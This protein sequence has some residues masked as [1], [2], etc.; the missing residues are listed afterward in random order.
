MLDT[1]EGFALFVLYVMT[2]PIR[3]ALFLAVLVFMVIVFAFAVVV[4][5]VGTLLDY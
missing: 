2:L 1:L 4:N 3:I 5:V